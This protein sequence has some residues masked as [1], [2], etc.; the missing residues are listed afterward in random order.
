MIHIE[1]NKYFYIIIK[2]MIVSELNDI[3]SSQSSTARYKLSLAGYSGVGKT[4]LLIRYK[5]KSYI[6]D[7]GTVTMIDHI[8]IKKTISNTQYIFDYY[9]TAGQ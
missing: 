4:K 2:P 1:K 7:K 8:P 3:Y 9:D 6:D 5:T